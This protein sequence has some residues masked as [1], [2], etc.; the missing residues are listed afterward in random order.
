MERKR[1]TRR[2]VVSQEVIVAEQLVKLAKNLMAE[3]SEDGNVVE[4][5]PK[6][7]ELKMSIK[8]KISKFNKK[9]LLKKRIQSIK[10]LSVGNQMVNRM[11]VMDLF[12]LVDEI[13][14]L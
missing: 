12:E 11:S 6:F 7:N 4:E 8:S 13:L 9:G 5:E 2:E 14:S 3:D 10:G 1:M